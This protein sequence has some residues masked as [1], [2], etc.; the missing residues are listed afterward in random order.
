MKLSLEIHICLLL[1]KF[2]KLKLIKAVQVMDA[3]L[4]T[5][6][7]VACLQGQGMIGFT[8]LAKNVNAAELGWY[9]DPILDACCQNIASDDDIWPHVVEM[10]VLLVTSTQRNNPRSPW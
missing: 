6:F 3:D 2:A 1:I 5:V 10:S 4:L 7:S 8:H 9:E